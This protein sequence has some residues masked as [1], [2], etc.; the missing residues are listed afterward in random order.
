MA[1]VLVGM[2]LVPPLWTFSITDEGFTVTGGV[3]KTCRVTGTLTGVVALEVGVMAILP[4]YVLGAR[5]RTTEAFRVAVTAPGAAPDVG[6]TLSH[7]PPFCVV[8]VA[9]KVPVP[10]S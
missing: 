8:A 10:D 2:L 3:G 1:S 9:V 6:T 7:V 5:P 4:W